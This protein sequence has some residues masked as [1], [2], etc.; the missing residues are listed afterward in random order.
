MFGIPCRRIFKGNFG[1]MRSLNAD[2]T[3]ACRC[4][5]ASGVGIPY[6]RTLDLRKHGKRED[7]W[8]EAC[9]VVIDNRN[10]DQ[11][12]R[13]AFPFMFAA[14]WLDEW[15]P[16]VGLHHAEFG[17]Q[18]FAGGYFE[19]RGSKQT[20]YAPNSDGTLNR[21][22]PYLL[23]YA[24][25]NGVPL[26]D[27][28]PKAWKNTPPSHPI[29][30]SSGILQWDWHVRPFE[31]DYFINGIP[32]GDTIT[33]K[34][35]VNESLVDMEAFVTTLSRDDSVVFSV[36]PVDRTKSW[37]FG[38]SGFGGPPCEKVLFSDPLRK[39]PCAF[40]SPG[41]DYGPGEETA[42]VISLTNARLTV[43]LVRTQTNADWWTNFGKIG[44]TFVNEG[45]PVRWI[46]VPLTTR[47]NYPDRSLG[48]AADCIFTEMGLC[49]DLSPVSVTF[50]RPPGYL[51]GSATEELFL[52]LRSQSI[53]INGDEVEP[54]VPDD[55]IYGNIN[56]WG[57]EGVEGN[58]FLFKANP[59]YSQRGHPCIGPTIKETKGFQ[60]P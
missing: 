23:A 51:F 18:N 50:G 57:S 5:C 11:A 25:I 48:E 46:E 24:T 47:N 17:A 8:I 12:S 54:L 14:M 38:L 53:S 34:W 39:I 43:S 4:N 37:A 6:G 35:F 56:E 16:Q 49:H 58:R 29:D 59:L 32:V 30:P 42:S 2:G 21:S 28:M 19:L 36:G 9:S 10:N 22:S 31:Y 40:S 33:L 44:P 52:E 41:K 13:R 60:L 26:H 27:I 45:S 15:S 7:G 3:V 20:G 1:E 55:G